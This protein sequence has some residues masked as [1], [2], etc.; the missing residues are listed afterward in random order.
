MCHYRI[1]VYCNHGRAH[2]SLKGV[3]SICSTDRSGHC[4]VHRAHQRTA[5]HPFRRLAARAIRIGVTRGA[6]T[7]ASAGRGCRRTEGRHAACRLLCA[8]RGG[9]LRRTA[10]PPAQETA[11]QAHQEQHRDLPESERL[12]IHSRCR[13]RDGRRIFNDAHFPP[14]SQ[15][16]YEATPQKLLSQSR[17]IHPELNRLLVDM[18]DADVY[19]NLRRAQGLLR[20][21]TKEINAAGHEVASARIVYIFRASSIT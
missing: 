11:H 4:R 20:S 5:P 15:A 17:F 1:N 6:Q 9:P 7:V 2:A 12:A 18:F 10:H 16:Y 19:G 14:V 21:C 13:R 3:N 8:G